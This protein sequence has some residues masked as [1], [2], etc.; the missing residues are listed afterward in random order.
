MGKGRSRTLR[1]PA[2]GRSTHIPN[3]GGGGV[4]SP[5]D[6]FGPNVDLQPV[7]GWVSEEGCVV[8]RPVRH[9]LWPAE[10][11]GPG[12]A[13]DRGDPVNFVRGCQP[14]RDPIFVRRV[15]ASFR[16]SEIGGR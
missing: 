1:S 4:G 14:E 9:R 8:A 13:R 10:L 7:A 6:L 12:A 15:T 2:R 5:R 11:G 16:N 3:A